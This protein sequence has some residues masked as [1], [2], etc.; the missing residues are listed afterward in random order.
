M[1]R[2]N[3]GDDVIVTFD[4]QDSPGEVLRASSGW[5]MCT[6]VVDPEYDY[7]NISARMA[8]QSTVCVKE[9][10]VRHPV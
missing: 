2:F 3:T 6:I 8:P 5:V 9:V 10:N 1:A 7:G 4:G